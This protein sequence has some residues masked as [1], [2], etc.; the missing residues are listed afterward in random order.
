MDPFQARRRRRLV[1]LC[2]ALV[3]LFGVSAAL[4]GQG[5]H[6]LVLSGG[7]LASDARSR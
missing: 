1:E 6:P 3:V 7:L 4:L 5:H 2:L